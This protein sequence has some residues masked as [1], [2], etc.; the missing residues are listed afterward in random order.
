MGAAIARD[1]VK[2]NEVD[3][4]AVCDVDKKRLNSL[5]QVEPSQKLSTKRHD[6]TRVP[7]TARF[8]K[9]F[10]LGV[11]AL[12]H[13]MS[14]Y[15]IQSTLQAGVSFV[16][17]IFGWRFE[18]SRIHVEARKKGIT[19][20]P[21]CGLAP[22]LTNILAMDAAER[23]GKTDEVHIKVGG[24][25]EKPKPP[26]N[27][28]IVFSFD[29]VLEEYVRKAR[30]VK[31]GRLTDVEALSGLETISF[32][33]PIGKCECFYTDGLSTL[34]STLKGVKEMDEKTIR[35]P[36]H[37]DQIRTLID[38]GLLETHPISVKGTRIVP[39]EVSSRIISK[40]ISLG[41]DTD[42]TLLRVDVAG[43]S[44]GK[45]IHMRYQMIDRYDSRLNMTSMARTTAF[46]CS[47]VT[48]MLGA[49]LIQDKG[50][51]PPEIAIKKGLRQKFLGQLEERGIR[52]SSTRTYS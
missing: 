20:I 2:S 19:I 16:D 25:P 4:V 30:I 17:L 10:D 14:E 28:R 41:N 31:R 23:L 42:L 39:R 13:G 43:R 52:I 6:V 40:R 36:G 47:V 35:W 15:A 50:L 8:L 24:I 12:P 21:A 29:A 38:L 37:V 45:R 46:P 1:L 7:E 51:V 5:A 48:Q 49:G 3:E 33:K 44:G 18:Q 26:L 32:P 27:Y 11:G 9:R 22:G 34:T